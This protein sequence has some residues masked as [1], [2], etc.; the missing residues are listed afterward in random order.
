MSS[1]SHIPKSR[2]VERMRESILLI[3]VSFSE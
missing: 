2:I 3:V 1:M